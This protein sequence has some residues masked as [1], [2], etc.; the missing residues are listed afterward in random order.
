MALIHYAEG[1]V[2]GYSPLG[3]MVVELTLSLDFM[4]REYGQASYFSADRTTGAAVRRIVSA[5][6][7]A[8]PS[9]QATG[10]CARR[11][12]TRHV[13]R[14]EARAVPEADAQASVL[15]EGLRCYGYAS[16]TG[17]WH[18]VAQGVGRLLIAPTNFQA[19]AVVEH[20][21]SGLCTNSWEEGTP[22]E[23]PEFTLDMDFVRREYGIHEATGYRRLITGTAVKLAGASGALQATAT[24]QGEPA[25]ANGPRR[26]DGSG[27]CA[28]RASVTNSV[29][30]VSTTGISRPVASVS[31]EGRVARAARGQT[32]ATSWARG[33]TQLVLVVD[34]TGSVQGTASAALRVMT[35][36]RAKAQL[37][38]LAQAQGAAT[39]QAKAAGAVAGEGRVRCRRL[40]LSVTGQGAQGMAQAHEQGSVRVLAASGHCMPLLVL[41][42][43]V[44]QQS[45]L[46]GATT[47]T[48]SVRGE[49][50]HQLAIRAEGRV[51]AR[52]IV[53]GYNQI[54]QPEPAPAGRTLRV[55]AQV[56]S[57]G[58][59][60]QDRQIVVGRASRA[61]AA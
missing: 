43:G 59:E 8:E 21:A 42:A 45:L 38:L 47:A 52:A 28:A 41:S 34:A 18:Q 11:L 23:T 31:G 51:E 33:D 53:G 3:S 57:F 5:A 48:A 50:V 60:R 55:E 9:A 22:G 14:I 16:V 58:I 19:T 61:L 7:R 32:Q 10:N 40:E 13:G 27:S 1:R 17:T 37:P 56:R 12:S 29:A 15:A 4:A 20:R 35:Y 54:N 25:T 30:R 2:T 49:A 36:R 24:V 6:G 39:M 44:R 26:L 46:A